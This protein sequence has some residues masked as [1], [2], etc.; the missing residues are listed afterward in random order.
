MSVQRSYNI[1]R[2]N[3]AIDT[4]EVELD[5]D[6]LP[7]ALDAELSDRIECPSYRNHSAAAIQ[8]D[9][10]AYVQSAL[11][12]FY[13]PFIADLQLELNAAIRAA[14]ALPTRS[15]YD[16]AID[17]SYEIGQALQS[18]LMHYGIRYVQRKQEQIEAKAKEGTG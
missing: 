4:I 14:S 8:E 17:K 15:P 6:Y 10:N 9:F 2:A 3:G 12:R 13:A 5:V 18:Y 11:D 16:V 7:L 1:M